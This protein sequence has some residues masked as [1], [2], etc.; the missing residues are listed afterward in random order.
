[1]LRTPLPNA[2]KVEEDTTQKPA[3]TK[4]TQMVRRAGM[5]MASI[6]SEALKRLRSWPGKSSATA[7]P[8]SMMEIAMMAA[9]FMVCRMRSFFRAP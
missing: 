7:R 9:S 1:M 6:S 5:P 2:W 8:T 4:L 3:N